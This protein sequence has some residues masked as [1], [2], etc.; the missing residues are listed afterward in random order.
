[1]PMEGLYSIAEVVKISRPADSTSLDE[2]EWPLMPSC[3]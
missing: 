3:G 2:A 1:M